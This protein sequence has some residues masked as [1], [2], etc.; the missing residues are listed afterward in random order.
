MY[1]PDEVLSMCR[2]HDF[3]CRR[4]WVMKLLVGD[5]SDLS[6]LTNASRLIVIVRAFLD[7]DVLLLLQ[8]IT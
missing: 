8:T 4:P 2:S 7:S 5:R 1:V 3:A 6:G